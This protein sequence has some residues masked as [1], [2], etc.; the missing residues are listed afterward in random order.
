MNEQLIKKI[1]ESSGKLDD[2]VN[3]PKIAAKIKS[4]PVRMLVSMFEVVDGYVFKIAL[5]EVIELIPETAHPVVES[6]LD[7]FISE[8]YLLIVDAAGAFL[9]QL[10]LIPIVKEDDQRN[11]YVALLT[12]IVR[13][14]PQMSNPENTD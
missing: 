1:K 5:T 8:D 6:F 13:L 11:V 9:T 3:F 7:A 12:A 2:F 14:I 10:N 4:K